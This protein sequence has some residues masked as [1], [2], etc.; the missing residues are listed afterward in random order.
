[1]IRSEKGFVALFTTILLSLLLIIIT[2]SLVT[3]EV[4]QLRKSNDS[5]QTLRAYYAAEAGIEDAVAKVMAGTIDKDSPDV[6]TKDCIGTATGTLPNASFD[7][8]GSAGWTCQRVTFSGSPT[9]KLDKADEAKTVDTFQAPAYDRIVVQWNQTT[10]PSAAFYDSNIVGGNFPAAGGYA[11]APPLEVSMLEYPTGGFSASDICTDGALPAG[12]RVKLRNIVI[13][14]DGTTGAY[15]ASFNSTSGHGPWGGNC[16]PL[17][18]T[19]PFAPTLSGYNC[20]A[21]IN[22]FSAGDSHLLRLRSRYGP[23]SYR[24]T[25]YNGPTQVDVPDGTATIDV[26]AKAGDTYRR[27]VS[28]LPLTSLA[29]S[30]LNYVIYSDSDICKNFSIINEVKQAGCGF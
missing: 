20:Y 29:S 14:P 22:G 8:A 21:V 7:A 26:T 3:L 10:N 1:M 16:G 6:T 11:W 19:V 2:V 4:A 23:S 17:P 15:T 25:F 18:R 28:K 9:G 13:V 12:C 27:V 5:E 24:L 30:G